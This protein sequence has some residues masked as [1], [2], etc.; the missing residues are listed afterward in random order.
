[1][2]KVRNAKRT[3][4]TIT[5]EVT[6][7]LPA[8]VKAKAALEHIARR[9]DIPMDVSEPKFAGVAVRLT[10]TK[11]EYLAPLNSG[12]TEHNRRPADSGHSINRSK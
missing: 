6:L 2:S 8:G 10:S 5:V 1:M 9:V 4:T 11:T 12:A 3:V 7:T